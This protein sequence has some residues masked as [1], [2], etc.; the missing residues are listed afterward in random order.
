MTLLLLLAELAVL[1]FLSRLLI[2]K[3]Y[4]FFLLVFRARSVA[5]SIVT[6]LLFPGTV[7]HELS[8]LFTA[9][10][11]G[12]RTG[13]LSLTPESI[14]ETS[15]KAGSV[16]IAQTGPIR[17]A[18]IGLSP[19]FAGLLSLAALSYFLP[20]ALPDWTNLTNWSYWDNP[21][22]YLFL[23]IAY[24]L[25]SVSNTMFSSREDLKGFWPLAITLGLFVGAAY[26]IGLRIG[27]E[28]KVLELATTILFALV[29]SLGLVLA[30]NGLLVLTL[31]V[32][33][34]LTRKLLR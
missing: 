24:L 22:A 30:V 34:V 8:H 18:A 23:L 13:K 16:S 28:G 15:I 7:I 2:Q 26:A 12:V 25:F 21:S 4:T 10:V 27:L 17:R 29:Q 33:L 1:L 32:L 6:L 11:L 20:E 5:V 14:R 9:E 19:I 31:H 3:L